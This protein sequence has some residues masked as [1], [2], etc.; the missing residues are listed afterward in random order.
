MSNFD[1]YAATKDLISRLDTDG[2]GAD[3]SKLRSAME[4][5]STGT[6]IFMMLRFHLLDIVQR[7]PLKGE[8]KIRA[9][10]LLAELND[11]L[12]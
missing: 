11:A 8:S 9:S 2:F 6:E 4:D 5:G 1:H 10:R 7:V 12:A 3:A